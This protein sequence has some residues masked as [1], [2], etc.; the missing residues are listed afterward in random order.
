[1]LLRQ[2][3]ESDDSREGLPAKW[4]ELRWAVVGSR[5]WRLNPYVFL[6]VVCLFELILDG[7]SGASSGS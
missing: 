4:T 5:E 6:L 1:M 2:A 3:L 7:V